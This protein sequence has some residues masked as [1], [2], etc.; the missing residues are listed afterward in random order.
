MLPVCSSSC[1]HKLACVQLIIH[2]VNDGLYTCQHPDTA[3]TTLASQP[4]WKPH[5][6]HHTRPYKVQTVPTSTL[7]A[8]TATFTPRSLLVP[9]CP[10]QNTFSALFDMFTST[11]EGMPTSV[12]RAALSEAERQLRLHLSLHESHSQP[13][14]P[15]FPFDPV[16]INA[17]LC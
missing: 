11:T 12:H 2:L 15:W 10:L 5:C 13:V 1:D 17:C 8:T 4:Q 14:Q 9:P 6:N 7:A 3:T 16:V